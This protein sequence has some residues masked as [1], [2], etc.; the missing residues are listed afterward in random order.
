MVDKIFYL[1]NVNS[2]RWFSI[3]AEIGLQTPVGLY[4]DNRVP[5]VFIVRFT[6]LSER[7]H[8]TAVAAISFFYQIFERFIS[9]V[10]S[11]YLYIKS[12]RDSNMVAFW[13]IITQ[14][15]YC[16]AGK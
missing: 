7:L 14:Y 4:S 6:Q 16:L 11:Y 8:R 12:H 1:V 15:K 13:L 3:R 9:K 2:Q 10:D 5:S